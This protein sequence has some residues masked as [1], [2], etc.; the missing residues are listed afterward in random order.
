MIAAKAAPRMHFFTGFLLNVGWVR[1]PR[2]RRAAQSN[3]PSA[4]HFLIF[5]IAA[6]MALAFAASGFSGSMG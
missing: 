6:I 4:L 2:R 1:R 3:G 5:S